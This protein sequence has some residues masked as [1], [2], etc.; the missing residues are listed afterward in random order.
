MQLSAFPGIFVTAD[1]NIAQIAFTVDNLCRKLQHM[2]CEKNQSRQKSFAA[3]LR[4][5]I[6]GSGCITL[7]RGVLLAAV[8]VGTMA[9]SVAAAPNS[10]SLGTPDITLGTQ[11]NTTPAMPSGSQGT[12]PQALRLANFGQTV[13]SPESQKLADWVVD[14]ADNGKLPFAIIDKVRAQVFVFNA[15][16]QLRGSSA[17]LLGLAIGDHTVPGIGQRK[18]S[19]IRPEERTTPAGRFVASLARD[20]HGEEVL[21]V[22]YENAVSLHRVVTGQPKERRAE[23]L[24]SPSPLDNR[25]SYGCINVPVKFYENVV[26]PSFTNSNGIVYIL[27]EIRSAQDVF[28]SYDVQDPSRKQ[29]TA[30]VAPAESSAAR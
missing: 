27:P 28:G 8:A 25:I 17:V 2:N 21:W 16:G 13:P 6:S 22:D 3:L 12:P 29:A 23:R 7:T 10:V 20:I 18:L 24:A 4:A 9:S 14:S 30:L 15:D 1:V 5:S 26:S 19:S 11:G